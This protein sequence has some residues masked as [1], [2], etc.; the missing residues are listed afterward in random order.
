MK[1]KPTVLELQ[2]LE[3]TEYMRLKPTNITLGAGCVIGFYRNERCIVVMP[4]SGSGVR[5][6]WP[7]TND[8][9]RIAPPCIKTEK[10]FLDVVNLFAAMLGLQAVPDSFE[11][12]YG[13]ALRLVKR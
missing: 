12:P 6:D 8:D 11:R 13:I 10:D 9:K 3:L 1:L 5:I 2:V 4:E 7:G